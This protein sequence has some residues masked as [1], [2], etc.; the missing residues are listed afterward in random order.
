MARP[1]NRGGRPGCDEVPFPYAC[2]AQVGK[3]KGKEVEIKGVNI[4]PLK[5]S[6]Y[7]LLPEGHRTRD[8]LKLYS[9]EELQTP[10]EG[11]SGHGGD[12]FTYKGTRYQVVRSKRYAMGVL[13]HFKSL[14]VS[15]E[16]TPTEE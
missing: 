12:E 2:K 13:D 14:A 6:E 3:G 4:Q 10:L 15:V 7:L 16:K 11:A 9:K 5:D 1:K 8:W